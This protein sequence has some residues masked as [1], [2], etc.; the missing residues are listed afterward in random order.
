MNNVFQDLW[1]PLLVVRVPSAKPLGSWGV[2]YPTSLQGIRGSCVVIPCTLSYPDDMAADDGI[3]AIWYKD[4]DNQKT[5]VYHS[6]AQEVDAG[7]RDRAQLLGDPAARNCTLLLRRLTL[8]D[9]GPYRFRFEIINGDRW[10][11]ER[12]V[13]LSVL[14]GYSGETPPLCQLPACLS[15]H[16]HPTLCSL[17]LCSPEGQ[18]LNYTWYKNSAW[19]K[20]GTAHTLL[21]HHVAASDAGYYSCKVTNDRGSDTSQ[22]VSLSV[23]LSVWFKGTMDAE[24]RGSAAQ[25]GPTLL[26]AEHHCV[27][28]QPSQD[29]ESSQPNLSIAGW[30]CSNL[31]RC[32][33]S[34]HPPRNLQMKAFTESGN[35]TAV[36]LLCVVES[37]PLS[38]ITLLKEGKLVAS[39][40]P[41]GGD[42]PRQSSRISLAPNTLRLELREAS[43]ED[44]GEYECQARSPLGSAYVSLPLRVQGESVF[45]WG[46]VGWGSGQGRG[47]WGPPERVG[48]VRLSCSA[49]ST[50]SHLPT[51]P[52]TGVPATRPWLPPTARPTHASPSRQPP[53]PCGWAWRGWSCRTQGSTSA[54][55]TTAMAPH[56]RPC[57]WM[58]EVRGAL[59]HS[60][61]HGGVL[62][63]PPMGVSLVGGVWGWWRPV[64][65][66]EPPDSS[67]LLRGHSHS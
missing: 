33:L 24:E 63:C 8:E 41:M 62:V 65:T 67:I 53:T 60:K 40:P 19:L 27:S 3:V 36:I 14:G 35:G 46:E 20:E 5:L 39:S 61:T 15:S 48:G 17:P 28:S 18:D 50:A 22:A 25:V 32:C 1:P 54:R 52:C 34:Y 7:F 13:M 51:S 29:H 38:K 43:A 57:S 44:E 10:S 66:Q 12:D 16:R 26:A 64:Q 31:L 11:A 59:S 47:G 55:P 37:N 23:T 42:H 4:Y 45:M 21:F 56:P 58:W 2:T 49:P 9:H 6:A 30:G